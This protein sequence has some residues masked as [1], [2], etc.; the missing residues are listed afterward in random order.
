M[1]AKPKVAFFDFAGCEG[2][3]LQVA[4]LEEKLLDLLQHIDLV[5]FREVMTEASDDY[6]IAFVEGSITRPEDAER[7]RGIREKAKVLVAIGA[8]ATIGGINCLKNFMDDAAYR[9]VVYG[10]RA[11]WFSTYAARPVR[12]VVPV[13]LEIHGCPIDKDE[14][15]RMVKELLLGRAP[16][17]PDYPVCME[18]K[19]AGNICNFERGRACLGM[20]TRAGCGAACVTEGSYCW[21]CRGLAPGANVDSA[22]AVIEDRA[23]FSRRESQDL[24]RMFLGRATAAL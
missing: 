6:D 7:V 18:C 20:I 11:R 9:Q 13:D 5:A 8:C 3:Q 24:M 19:R 22:R 16:W 2:D 23:G 15:L 4:N 14:F 17:Q 12:E 1:A 10:D 21:G